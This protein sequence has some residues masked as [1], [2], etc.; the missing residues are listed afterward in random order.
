MNRAFDALRSRIRSLPTV[1]QESARALLER[2]S[3]LRARLYPL[4]DTRLITSRIRQ[5]GDYQL[6]NIFYTGNDFVIA[7]FEGNPERPLSERRIKRSAFR[8]VSSMIRSFHY[9]SHAVLYGQVP[10]IVPRSEENPRLERWANAWYIWV[11]AAFLAAYMEFGD[12]SV[13]VP[14]AQKERAIL[15]ESY[16]I[17]KALVEIEFELAHRPDWVSIPVNGILDLLR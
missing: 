17:E 14:Q 12:G 2:E 6:S 3:E 16:T 15:L 13:F 4:R 10:G 7:N 11:S 9:I 8:D 1:V 5:H